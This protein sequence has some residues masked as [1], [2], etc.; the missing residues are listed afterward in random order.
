[1]Y[2]IEFEADVRDGMI[3]IPSQYQGIEAR[4]VKVIALL[5]DSAANEPAVAQEK[6]NF[7]AD[8]YIDQHWRELIVTAS[9]EALQDDD[10]VLQEEYGDFLS[11]KHSF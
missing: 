2:A 5:E 1:M 3:K 8:G 4:H 7:F 10:A 9:T 6:P 11:A